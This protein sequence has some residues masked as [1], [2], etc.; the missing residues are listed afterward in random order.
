MPLRSPPEEPPSYASSS[1]A[2]IVLAETTTVTT[3]TTTRLLSFPLFRRRKDSR[4]KTADGG[5]P[6]RHWLFDKDLPPTPPEA[7]VDEFGKVQTPP[8]GQTTFAL[9]QASL[10]LGLPHTLPKS[11]HDNSINSVIFATPKSRPSTSSGPTQPFK[12]KM[13]PTSEKGHVPARSRGISLGFTPS[14]SS[15][16]KSISRR[17]SFWSKRRS[18]A[19]IELPV[20]TAPVLPPPP[21]PLPTLPV[22]PPVSPLVME[23]TKSSGHARGLSRSHSE[24]NPRTQPTPARMNSSPSLMQRP[25]TAHSTSSSHRLSMR[26]LNSPLSSSPLPTPS[27]DSQARSRPRASTNPPLL[28]RL[29]FTLGFSPA[30][31]SGQPDARSSPLSASPR[32]S[33]QA[34][35]PPAEIPKPIVD[36]ESPDV[37]LARLIAAVSKAEVAG[38]LASSGDPFHVSALRSYIE[39]F[40]F[41]EDP[42]DIALRKLLMEVGLPRETQQ[43]DRVMEAFAQRYVQCNPDL[44]SSDDHPYILAFSLIMLHTDAFN[45]SNKR[46][47]TKADYIKN[48][49]LP[50]IQP[51]I[52]DYFYDNIVFAPFI[53]IEDPLD[54]N[55]QRGLIIEHRS[56]KMFTG[57]V[58]V[59]LPNPGATPSATNSLFRSDRVDPYYLI[60]QHQ[61]GP[62][63]VNVEAY[64]PSKNPYAYEG[65]TG[66]WDEG[67]LQQAFANAI[68]VGVDPGFTRPTPFFGMAVGG[69][70]SPLVTASSIPTSANSDFP[71]T[72]TF[73]VT[74]LGILNR[75]DHLIE[76]GRRGGNR[77]WRQWSVILTGSQL[78]LLRDLS[79]VNTLL[80][81]SRSGQ[82]NTPQSTAF[83]PDELVSVKDAVAVFDRSYTKHPNTF[84]LALPNGRQ[85]LLQT[86]SEDDMNEWISRINYASAFKSAGMRMRSQPM[87]RND[88]RLTGIAAATS[89]LH[90]MQHLTSPRVRTAE[91]KDRSPAERFRA[92]LST[93]ADDDDVDVPIAPEIEGAEQFEIT[94]DQVKAELAAGRWTTL[95][96]SIDSRPSSFTQGSEHSVPSTSRSEVV[97]SKLRD[98]EAKLS[99]SQTQLDADLRFVRNIGIA[100]PF[101]QAT[102]NR[103]L[104][105]LQSLSVRIMQTRLEVVKFG[106]HKH[107]LAKD[108]ELEQRDWFLAKQMA[109]QVATE[110]LQ[111]KLEEDLP[112]MTLS[113]HPDRT[114]TRSV[115]MTTVS[116]RSSSRRPSS[117]AESF[118]S[119]LDFGLDWSVTDELD[120]SMF[121]SPSQPHQ[122][123]ISR[124]SSSSSCQ[125]SGLLN[126]RDSSSARVTESPTSRHSLTEHRGSQDD[127]KVP[128]NLIT[129]QDGGEQAEEWDKTRCARRGQRVSLVRMPSG[130][131]LASLFERHQEERIREGAGRRI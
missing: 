116:T 62:L 13:S 119:A 1:S 29:S 34:L 122:D 113:F 97:Q 130:A 49:R 17:P 94:F 89:H 98:L 48:T 71:G 40:D 16:E 131:G 9:A 36:R 68:P 121:L 52:L 32:Q 57:S 77:K 15:E 25:S 21:L 43:I 56:S 86:T 22:I 96:S 2:P 7:H 4:P 110:T 54:V 51:E 73:R 47:M 126:R 76:G 104:A 35:R 78:L 60:Q 82:V 127:W 74:K 10:G 106:C 129:P 109:L 50:G 92:E 90:D 28:N 30:S 114:P 42:L 44:F 69:V 75:K 53:F 101:Q 8:A 31:G 55:G 70:P 12:L 100:T 105:A 11:S 112:K 108:L 46:K 87:S 37:Y 65:S 128:D 111:S 59:S 115:P 5:R 3:T 103:L 83:R 107:I 91:P 61:L 14:H 72:W 124:T 27:L 67:I 23:H 117:S 63:R 93:A 80:E 19:S 33:L 58:D 84:M 18:K 6:T 64:V 85:I 38:I 125:I 118:H 81:R 41:A 26:I 24:R 123:G 99:A 120:S 88:A 39:Q 102:R 79:W 20:E 66:P 45:K 95:D